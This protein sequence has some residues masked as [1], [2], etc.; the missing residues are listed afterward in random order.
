MPLGNET[1]N[2]ILPAFY[3]SNQAAMVICAIL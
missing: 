2:P 1:A 3:I